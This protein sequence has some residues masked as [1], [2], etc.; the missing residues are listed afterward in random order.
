MC[1]VPRRADRALKRLAVLVTLLAAACRPIENIRPNPP[2]PAGPSTPIAKTAEAPT[3]PVAARSASGDSTSRASAAPAVE[4]VPLLAPPGDLWQHIRSHEGFVSCERLSPPAARWLQ[5]FVQRRHALEPAFDR[6]L[7]QIALVAALLTERGLPAEFAML[8]MVESRYRPVAAKGGGAAGIWQLMPATARALEVPITEDF[9]GRLDPLLASR[10]AVRLL[11]ELGARFGHDW[12][13][14]NMAFNAGEYRLRRALRIQAEASRA[15]R[16]APLP[17]AAGTLAHLAQLEA[18]HC[19]VVEAPRWGF[20]LPA[21]DRSR[22]LASLPLAQPM[23]IDFLADQI[24]LSEAEL[25]ALNPA[26]DGL[27][28]TPDSSNYAL[29]LSQSQWP[30]ANAALARL[31]SLPGRTWAR[32]RLSDRKNWAALASDHGI[33]VALLRA[34]N[35]R[36]PSELAP[37]GAS[38]WLPLSTQKEAITR[39]R[40]QPPSTH[41]VQSG[42]TFWG[43]ARRYRLR[44][45]ELLRW[46]G[47]DP[48]TPL[49]PGQLLRLIAP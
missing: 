4:V 17:I 42:D 43:I 6:A 40:S 46:N 27:T 28:Q 47:A 8:P 21:I 13:L 25:R 38:I 34:I 26:L 5:R 1:R 33:D 12:R 19:L 41:T 10:A 32:Q 31:P 7:P 24:E 14:A 20:A 15:G 22:L 39:A 36:S 48:N 44:L 16:P 30:K 49:R 29:L 11:A 45:T 9:D 23:M 37:V 3:A 18:L 2:P 35:H